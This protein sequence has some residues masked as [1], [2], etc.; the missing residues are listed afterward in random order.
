[1]SEVIDSKLNE[2][3]AKKFLESL[4]DPERFGYSVTEEVRDGA[5]ELLGI[6]KVRKV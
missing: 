1:M 3:E 2:A 6:K 4:L 5:R